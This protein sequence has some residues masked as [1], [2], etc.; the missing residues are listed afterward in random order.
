MTV[1]VLK[2]YRAASQK[3]MQ[4]NRQPADKNGEMVLHFLNDD[5][6]PHPNYQALQ[7]HK[8]AC[9][10]WRMAG[11]AEPEEEDLEECP[12]DDDDDSIRSLKKN[13]H[14]CLLVSSSTLVEMN[15]IY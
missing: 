2:A 9:L 10:I 7:F 12:D 11:G 15:E 1:E 5:H 8:T 13:F 6:T 14:L 3:F 4:D